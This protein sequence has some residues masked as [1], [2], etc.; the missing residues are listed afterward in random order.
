[1]CMAPLRKVA[2]EI[3]PPAVL[4]V[5]TNLAVVLH[6]QPMQLEQPV[7][8][9]LSVPAKGH[10]LRV[11]DGRLLLVVVSVF[12]ALF[13][14]CAGS[15]LLLLT[16]SHQLSMCARLALLSQLLRGPHCHLDHVG[17]VAHGV[18]LLCQL[19]ELLCAS[20]RLGRHLGRTPGCGCSCSDLFPLPLPR[21]L[22]TGHR[23][24]LWRVLGR[25][26]AAH[27]E[28]A[29][30]TL[31]RGSAALEAPRLQRLLEQFGV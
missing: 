10:I 3:A 6:P 29:L 14:H 30:R 7:R 15:F 23:K 8:D 5:A 2:L 25:R 12:L 31:L 17:D 1:M 16:L 13:C 11:V 26:E 9:G 4:D 28:E 20:T 22:A 24:Y 18:L 19:L 27:G 21:P